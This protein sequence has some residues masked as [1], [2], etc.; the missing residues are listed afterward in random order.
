MSS[1]DHYQTKQKRME[2][3][4]FG[5]DFPTLN[6]KSVTI[7]SKV[8][9]LPERRSRRRGSRG[10]GR[11]RGRKYYTLPHPP[12]PPP[13]VQLKMYKPPTFSIDLENLF[14]VLDI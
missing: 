12:Q 9:G 11:G 6:R 7:A 8:L 10:R 14:E 5:L 4:R 2:C 3:F 1:I 13:T